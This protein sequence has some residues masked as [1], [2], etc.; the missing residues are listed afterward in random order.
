MAKKWFKKAVQKGAT[1]N[2][3]GWSKDMS[4]SRRRWRAIRSRPNQW[5]ARKKNVSAG[6]ALQALSNVTKDRAT[7]KKAK[8]DADYFFRKAKKMKK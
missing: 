4:A 5:S 3:D 2:L 6:R 8:A 7:K 1:R